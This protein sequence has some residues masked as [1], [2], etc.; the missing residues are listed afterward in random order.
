M[1]EVVI[2]ILWFRVY[3][4]ADI[5]DKLPVLW[6]EV[7]VSCL[8]YSA[9][10]QWKVQRNDGSRRAYSQPRRTDLSVLSET[11]RMGRQA[12]VWQDSTRRNRNRAAAP[13]APRRCCAGKVAG[14]SPERFQ[15]CQAAI[16][17][18]TPAQPWE[19]LGGLG[20]DSVAAP[21]CVANLP[22]F[23]KSQVTAEDDVVTEQYSWTTE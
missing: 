8:S 2:P 5:E 12:E 19:T 23:T 11:C 1:D 10:G 6:S 9:H 15:S 16:D 21:M 13:L 7:L 14:Q 4:I 17:S 18:H 20:A 3:L 22:L